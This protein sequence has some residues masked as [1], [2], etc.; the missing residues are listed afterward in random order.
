MFFLTETQLTQNDRGIHDLELYE[1]DSE[2][3]EGERLTRISA[4]ESGW[5]P[6]SCMCPRSPPT[7]PL[8]ISWPT[9]CLLP[10]LAPTATHATVGHCERPRGRPNCRS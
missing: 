10:I 5:R 2:A 8:F 7:V 6:A 1:Y 3:P 4:G 9:V